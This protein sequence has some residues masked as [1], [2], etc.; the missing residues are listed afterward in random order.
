MSIHDRRLPEANLATV[1]SAT[2]LTAC[3]VM[4]DRQTHSIDLKVAI[5]AANTFNLNCLRICPRSLS[6]QCCRLAVAL[7]S[8]SHSFSWS[9]LAWKVNHRE[10]FECTHLKFTVSGQFKHT[11]QLAYTHMCNAVILRVGSLRLYSSEVHFKAL[12]WLGF[13]RVG[14]GVI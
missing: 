7:H 8:C 1:H 3:L 6:R 10:I 14:L 12:I 13:I 4:C 11:N 9:T 5:H 2:S